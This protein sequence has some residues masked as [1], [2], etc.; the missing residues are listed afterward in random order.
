MLVKPSVARASVVFDTA[1]EGVDAKQM[2][3]SGV[4]V[5]AVVI[6]AGSADMAI[7]LYDT[8]SGMDLYPNKRLDLACNQGESMPFTPAQPIPFKKG[9]YAVFG[10]GGKAFGGKITLVVN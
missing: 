4:E 5:V 3:S 7:A 2:A 9:V 10:Q 1:I 6:T 8:D